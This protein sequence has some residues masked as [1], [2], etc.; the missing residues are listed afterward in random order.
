MIQ[1]GGLVAVV[2]RVDRGQEA[3]P[4]RPV[5]GPAEQ[6]RHRAAA[7]QVPVGVGEQRPPQRRMV[8]GVLDHEVGSPFLDATQDALVQGVVPVHVRRRPR[9]RRRAV[10]RPA[11]RGTRPRSATKSSRSRR[12]V[13][14]SK[15]V[16]P[17]SDG[18]KS[19]T[20]SSSAAPREPRE[21]GRLRDARLYVHRGIDDGQDAIDALHIVPPWRSGIVACLQCA[22]TPAPRQCGEVTAESTY[23][24][25]L[26]SLLS[27]A[28]R[29][30]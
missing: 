12:S 8:V 3:R 30:L 20:K 27:P 9:G 5:A 16:L 11:T 1:C 6:Q 15:N 25:G 7:D 23:D 2:A 19:Q 29:D 4:G 26:L 14:S 13:P 10:R 22:V 21:A 28:V 18:S 17:A 24:R